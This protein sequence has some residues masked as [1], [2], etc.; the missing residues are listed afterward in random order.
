MRNRIILGASAC[1]LAAAVAAPTAPAAQSGK[2][3]GKLRGYSDNKPYK[4]KSAT[5]K[6]KVSG[7]KVKGFTATPP[8]WCIGSPFTFDDDHM[9]ITTVY[10][11]KARIKGKSFKKTYV[12]R[13]DD[14]RELGRNI[15]KGKFSGKGA[16]GT[17]ERDRSSCYGTYRWKVKLRR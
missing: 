3:R 6:F 12:I 9:E 16:S 5:V 11:P 2:Y 15:L 7:G 1:L 17:I 13:D 10:V 4:G 14:G 8:L